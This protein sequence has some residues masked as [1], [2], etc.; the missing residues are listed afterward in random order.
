[1]SKVTQEVTVAMWM[2]RLQRLVGTCKKL[3]LHINGNLTFWFGG[4]EVYLHKVEIYRS[5][6]FW[7]C[8]VNDKPIPL[9]PALHKAD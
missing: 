8:S 7:F 9:P 6:D 5:G 1:M 3:N 4:T 2:G